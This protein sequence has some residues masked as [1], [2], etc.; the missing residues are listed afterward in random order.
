MSGED[1][2]LA[3]HFKYEDVSQLQHN[4]P[5]EYS[6]VDNMPTNTLDLPPPP[7]PPVHGSRENSYVHS[8]NL[9]SEPASDEE[10]VKTKPK[11]SFTNLFQ[12][13][14]NTDKKS[15]HKTRSRA[16]S[17][18]SQASNDVET[19][20]AQSAYAY[21]PPGVDL[22]R[23][24]QP[25][26]MKTAESYS[27]SLA[28]SSVRPTTPV[29]IVH[30]QIESPPHTSTAIDHQATPR[31][32]KTRS[33]AD[34]VR[35]LAEMHRELNIKRQMLEQYQQE[36]RRLVIEK[37]S[38]YSTI[39]KRDIERQK[40]LQNFDEYLQSVRATPDTL[41][42]IYDQ[43]H[44]LKIMIRE[45]V[46]ELVAKAD[47]KIATKILRDK[48][49]LNMEDTIGKLGKPLKR[50]HIAML[51]E[52]YIMDQ[53][54]ECV[55]CLVSY[56]GL[57]IDQAY[58]D[59]FDWVEEQD[60]RFAIRLRQEMARVVASREK[61]DDTDAV[62]K[63]EKERVLRFLC[64][65]LALAFP[66]IV[67]YDKE[68]V[69]PQKRFVAK[70]RRV[71]EQAFALSLAMKGQEVEITTG[72]ILVGEQKFDPS[73]MEDEEG[74]DSGIVRFCIYPPFIDRTGQRRFLEK[75]RVYC[76]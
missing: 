12:K 30:D 6:T 8:E 1:C 21:Y 61:G 49:W 67:S 69:D 45:V 5:I 43:I 28:T 62:V 71:V 3:G 53:L 48:F 22:S 42:T 56:P 46:D 9:E 4:Q 18:A 23:A 52:K 25:P 31:Q 54:V 57:P 19:S 32:L 24:K 63:Q 72:Q 13:K 33:L 73:I 20:L 40:L 65:R 51:T 16:T 44:A 66:F 50:R 26:P 60:E 37:E 11:K 41:T 47:R 39:E 14:K 34:P 15:D 59:L 10:T 29:S 75:A 68:E 35:A 55:F 38:L 36:N 27:S 70:F 76:D 74:K 7:P 64:R 58:S 17:R 2:K